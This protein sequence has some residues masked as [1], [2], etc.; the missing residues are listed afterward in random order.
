MIAMIVN[1]GVLYRPHVLR[2]IRDPLTG[3]LIETTQP[4]IVHQNEISDATYHM[5]RDAMRGVLT[6]GTANVVITTNAVASAGKTGTGQ[7]AQQGNLNSWFAAYAP[8]GEDVDPA[9]QIV[10][11]VMVDAM[12]EWEW[13]APKA[14]NIIL[15]GHFRGLD[16]DATIADLRRGPRPL[17]YM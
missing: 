15:H 1:D 2:E 9:E 3:R 10:V 12:N 6:Q 11:V 7:T 5:V 4:E 8:H 13:W 14:A 16:Y 17:W